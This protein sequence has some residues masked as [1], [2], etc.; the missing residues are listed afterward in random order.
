M[1]KKR[2][3]V[4]EID[5]SNEN[6]EYWNEILNSF[7]LSMQRGSRPNVVTPSGNLTNLNRIE[8]KS[9]QKDSGRVAP[10]GSKPE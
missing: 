5:H 10:A 2:E 1:R 6:P 3:P 9:F 7:G 8:I 4:T